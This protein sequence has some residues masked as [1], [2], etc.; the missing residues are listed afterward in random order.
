MRLVHF[1]SYTKNRPVLVVRI[2]RLLI[3]FSEKEMSLDTKAVAQEFHA[4]CGF[5][6][7]GWM[8]AEL[9]EQM[10]SV[11]SDQAIQW[12]SMFAQQ[13]EQK[14]RRKPDSAVPIATWRYAE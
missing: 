9:K 6:S 10:V 12:R 1:P 3:L 13:L 7:V 4:D 11:T 14:R 2:Y 8:L 5:Q